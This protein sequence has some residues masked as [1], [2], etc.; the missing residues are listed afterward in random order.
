MHESLRTVPGISPGVGHCLTTIPMRAGDPCLCGPDWE[1]LRNH[2][3]S[4]DMSGSPGVRCLLVGHRGRIERIALVFHH[5]I[6]DGRGAV[7]LMGDLLRLTLGVPAKYGPQPFASAFEP[8][9][10]NERVRAASRRWMQEMHAIQRS[11]RLPLSPDDTAPC[12][13]T[14]QS[15]T[16]GT[17]SH[18]KLRAESQALGV[19]THAMLS[20]HALLA[21]RDA[22]GVGDV[23]VALSHAVDMRRFEATPPVLACRAGL[24]LG[25]H[26]ISNNDCPSTVAVDVHTQVQAGL[27][28]AFPAW[29]LNVLPWLGQAGDHAADVDAARL[30][31]ASA[32]SYLVISDLGA[33]DR[34]WHGICDAVTQTGLTVQPLPGQLAVLTRIDLAGRSHLQLHT[35]HAAGAG[36]ILHHFARGLTERLNAHGRLASG[37]PKSCLETA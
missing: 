6:M 29:L 10:S 20:G 15:I 24:L 34:E 22:M 8:V 30:A 13:P 33:V 14:I 21:L 25:R 18:T 31:M 32:P 7:A 3:L 27:D 28:C 16:L 1:Y 11:V 4:L 37:L 9:V 23:S 19:S 36:A 2:A 12:L 35:R 26:R 5:A 17:G